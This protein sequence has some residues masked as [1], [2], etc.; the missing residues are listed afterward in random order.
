M[1]TNKNKLNKRS[2]QKLQFERHIIE[3]AV[4]EFYDEIY[5]YLYLCGCNCCICNPYYGDIW[6][7]DIMLDEYREQYSART[8]T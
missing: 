7:Y 3:D 4:E 1:R 6:E 2:Q 5:E 8:N